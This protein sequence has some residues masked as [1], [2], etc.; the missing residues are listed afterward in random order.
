MLHII[1]TGVVRPRLG[2][3]IWRT[4]V[5]HRKD[6]KSIM[7]GTLDAFKLKS[8]M[9]YIVKNTNPLNADRYTTTDARSP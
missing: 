6:R 5:G 7:K 4:F 3:Q 9:K 8:C 2:W 1:D